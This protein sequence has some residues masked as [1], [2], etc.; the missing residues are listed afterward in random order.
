MA[1][2]RDDARVQLARRGLSATAVELVAR[3]SFGRM[4]ITLVDRAR[5]Q[6]RAFFSDAPW[7]VE[8]DAALSAVVGPGAGWSV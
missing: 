8:D 7:T 2:D 5:N 1:A 4:P 6:L 3:T